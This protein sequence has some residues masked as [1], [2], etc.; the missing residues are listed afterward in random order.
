VASTRHVILRHD[1]P[2]S[3]LACIACI[4]GLIAIRRFLIRRTELK[5]ELVEND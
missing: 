2:S 3:N 5:E 1:D 4:A